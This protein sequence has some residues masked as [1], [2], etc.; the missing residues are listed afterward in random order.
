MLDNLPKMTENHHDFFDK[1]PGL[2]ALFENSIDLTIAMRDR[3]HPGEAIKNFKTDS[4]EKL[5]IS[6]KAGIQTIQ[7]FSE[8]L[9]DTTSEENSNYWVSYDQVKDLVNNENAFKIFLGLLSAK[10][11]NQNIEF[12]NSKKLS[13]IINNVGN[14]GYA[15]IKSYKSFYKKLSKDID[16]LNQ[17]IKANKKEEKEEPTF[18]NAIKYFDTTVDILEYVTELGDLLPRS[19]PLPKKEID[20]SIRILRNLSH[21]AVNVGHK[22]YSPAIIN[23]IGVVDDVIKFSINKKPESAQ[24]NIEKKACKNAKK[25]IKKALENSTLNCDDIL[26]EARNTESALMADTYSEYLSSESIIKSLDT[27]RLYYQQEWF[28]GGA[29]DFIKKLTKYGTFMSALTEA[30]NSDAVA[31]I[32]ESYILPVGSARIKRSSTFNVA[33]NAYIGPFI[34]DDYGLHDDD[35]DN[36]DE[37]DDGMNESSDSSGVYGITAPVGIGISKG[38]GKNSKWSIGLFASIIDI[39]AITS[40][41]FKDVE[42]DVPKIFLREIFSPGA[43]LSIGLPGVISVNGGF[44]R[45]SLLRKIGTDINEVALDYNWRLSASIVVDIPLVNFY[46]KTK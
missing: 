14:V 30:E 46:T 5:D 2:K 45:A 26:K 29:Q 31:A 27:I 15:E 28:T 17:L 18:E 25:E 33:L 23:A 39:G 19:V 13:Y 41:R 32:I 21:L 43:F 40:F 12:N 7:L 10:A 3:T 34:G 38:L 36:K 16:A 35:K 6:L 20:R 44:Q 1:N 9:R 8:A 42:S 11:E 24:F 4:I 22:K 37:D